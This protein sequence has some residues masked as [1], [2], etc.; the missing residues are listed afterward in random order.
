MLKKMATNQ[1]SLLEL[2]NMFNFWVKKHPKTG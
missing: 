1:P 2:R